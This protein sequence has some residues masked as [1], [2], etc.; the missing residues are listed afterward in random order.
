MSINIRR[1]AAKYYERWLQLWTDYNRF[2][3]HA[4]DDAVT[5]YT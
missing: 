4:P 3:A 2:Y 5:A 1:I